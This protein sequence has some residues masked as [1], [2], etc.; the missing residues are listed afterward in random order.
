MATGLI[1]QRIEHVELLI[2][3]TELVELDGHGL[4]VP[5]QVRD[6]GEHAVGLMLQQRRV[7]LVG[8][9]SGLDQKPMD[10]TLKSPPS[11]R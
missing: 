3:Q 7:A 2:T 1:G 11:R 10:H 5:P 9:H 4:R 8:R 6:E